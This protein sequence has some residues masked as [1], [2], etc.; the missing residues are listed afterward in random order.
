M[1]PAASPTPVSMID[2]VA[3]ILETFDGPGSL[4]L[5]Q[6][7]IRTGLPRSSAH[8]ILEHLVKIRWLRREDN[9]YH[10]GLRM[11]ELGT[12]AAHQHE[13][14]GAATVALHELAHSTGMVVHLAVLDGPDVVYLDK[15]GGR[16][17]MRVPSRIGGRAPAHCTSVGKAMLAFAGES[18]LR[19]VLDGPMRRPTAASIGT[20]RG[21]RAELA[22]VRDRSAAFDREE[23]ARGLACVAAPVGAPGTA[24]AAISVCGPVGRVNFE[25]L[26]APVRATAHAVWSSCVAGRTAPQASIF[27][28]SGSPW[29]VGA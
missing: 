18:G 5:S 3:Q 26:I 23:S 6:V 19:E 7:V 10:L 22:R 2:R 20:E 14:R 15:I 12:L 17:G 27:D 25:Q 21:L 29:V 11:M 1:S 24:R 13:L 8:R 9:S 16:F 28:R 4:T